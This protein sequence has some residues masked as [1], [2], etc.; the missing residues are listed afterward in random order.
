MRPLLFTIT[1]LGLTGLSQMPALTGLLGHTHRAAAAAPAATAG[2]A[3]AADFI[4]GFPDVP[5]LAGV[6]E[7]TPDARIIFD[8]PAGTVAETVIT[9]PESAPVL[10]SKYVSSLRGLGWL[11]HKSTTGLDCRRSKNRLTLTPVASTEIG[12]NITIRLE[13]ATP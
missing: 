10:L 11:C 6:K 7:A 13:P 12:S 1:I 3:E 5:L 4:D 9:S 2:Q 8:T